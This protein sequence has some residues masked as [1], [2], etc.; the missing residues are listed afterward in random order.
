MNTCFAQ[1]IWYISHLSLYKPIL[2][3]SQK[4]MLQIID[5]KLKMIDVAELFLFLVFW[6]IMTYN[7]VSAESMAQ[8]L[9][10]TLLE[11]KKIIPI[12]VTNY[13]DSKTLNVIQYY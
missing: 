10:K 2:I 12:S 1:Y 5:K 11:N 8:L 6:E 13:F 7:R 4:L 3:E 9:W